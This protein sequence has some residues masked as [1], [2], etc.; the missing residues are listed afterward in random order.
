MLK[1]LIILGYFCEAVELCEKSGYSI[2]GIV[3]KFP[4]K[5]N[6]YPYLGDDDYILN[7]DTQYHNIPFFMVPDSPMQ[8]KCLYD[9]YHEKGFKFETVISPNALVSKSAELG[10][11]CMIQ[12]GCNISS[13]VK[14]GK[15]V[16]VNCM[17]NIMHECIIDD[18]VTIAP[19]AVV[20]GR[21]HVKSFSYVGAN[22]T[23]LPYKTIGESVIV[24]AGA[25][26]TKNIEKEQTVI[27]V[28]ARPHR[29]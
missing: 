24:G 11:G 7:H 25:V 29:S 2:V 26:V 9:L 6:K 5:D 4:P 12:D 28:P 18:F 22:A 15:M 20:L 21:C 16:R 27:G 1:D 13:G 10:E 19:S 3:D 23:I 14:L 8:R 17:A